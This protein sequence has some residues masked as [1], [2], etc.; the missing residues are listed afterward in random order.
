ME[1]Y[2]FV[3]LMTNRY[4]TVIYTGMTSNLQRRIYEH[5]EKIIK[6]FTS[7]Y[8]V[9]KLVYYEYYEDVNTAIHREKEIKGG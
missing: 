9:E 4:N 6:G 1:K 5:K 8:N 7:K 3:Y 2:Y